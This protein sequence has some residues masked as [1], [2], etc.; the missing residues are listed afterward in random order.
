MTTIAGIID[1]IILP[2]WG[3]SAFIIPALFYMKDGRWS[4]ENTVRYVAFA[5]VMAIFGRYVQSS[6][7][8][9]REPGMDTL[10]IEIILLY[11]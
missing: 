3:L 2:L 8:K 7:I 10:K 1:R 4:L 5:G 9:R 6:L 11:Y